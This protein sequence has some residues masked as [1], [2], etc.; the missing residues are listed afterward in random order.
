MAG[1]KQTGS[2]HQNILT[3]CPVLNFSEGLTLCG[4]D[5]HTVSLGN[6]NKLQYLRAKRLT[7]ISFTGI[8]LRAFSFPDDCK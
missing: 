5:F 3:T 8:A 2:T 7:G 4:K 6:V 1:K